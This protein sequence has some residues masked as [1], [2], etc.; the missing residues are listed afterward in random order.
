MERIL[1]VYNYS[2][3]NIAGQ[4]LYKGLKEHTGQVEAIG[5]HDW[6]GHIVYSR[7]LKPLHLLGR[8]ELAV[9]AVNRATRHGMSHIVVWDNTFVGLATCIAALL[10]RFRGN[11]VVANVIDHAGGVKQHRRQR[12]GFI[13]H[14][15]H[16]A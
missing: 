11:I 7:R 13:A 1:L 10:L 4:W 6:F 12:N 14:S 16:V 2:A 8:M 15:I 9:R 3:K 5:M